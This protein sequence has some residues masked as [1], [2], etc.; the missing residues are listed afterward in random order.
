[1]IKNSSTI[2]LPV[3]FGGFSYGGNETCRIG[4]K[5]DRNVCNI[6]MADESFCGR[7]LTGKLVLGYHDDQPGQRILFEDGQ[8]VDGVFDAKQISLTPELVK[9]G[10][11]FNEAS[12]PSDV[13][14]SFA[15]QKGRMLV[16]SIEDIP[17]DEGGDDV[18]TSE[19]G[20]LPG[21]LAVDGEWKAAKLTSLLSKSI[22]GK[23]A[24][25]KITTMGDLA[26][27][28]SADKRLDDIK[29]LGPGS[30]E[31]IEEM[32]LAFWRDNEVKEPANA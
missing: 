32:T 13:L 7:R 29:G 9:F 3:E 15:K 10:A 5:I 26:A 30:V 6:N 1:M 14:M 12:I 27:Y 16:E 8:C 24:K 25:A 11:T 23:L 22:A 21:A 17:E 28:T 18:D 20:I 4:I 19:S 31:K 2:D